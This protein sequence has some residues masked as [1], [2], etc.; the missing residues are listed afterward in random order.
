VRKSTSESGRNFIKD[1]KRALALN[2]PSISV[3]DSCIISGEENN[4]PVVTNETFTP[5]GN[6]LES[7]LRSGPTI[8]NLDDV[9]IKTEE[10]VITLSTNSPGHRNSQNS[11]AA[12][13]PRV[14]IPL[15]TATKNVN[16]DV[17]VNADVDRNVKEFPYSGAYQKDRKFFKLFDLSRMR[18][19]NCEFGGGFVFHLQNPSKSQKRNTNFSKN[20]TVSK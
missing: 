19:I 5:V 2:S 12:I 9:G 14:L 16:E 17:V 11:T 15:S 20:K 10:D 6:S 1:V 4:D 3:D 7:V 8:I 18:P 13:K